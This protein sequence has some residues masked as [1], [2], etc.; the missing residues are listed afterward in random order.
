VH[1]SHE[2]T[3]IKGRVY[4][5]E[6]KLNRILKLLEETSQASSAPQPLAEKIIKILRGLPLD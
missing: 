2:L 4:Q 6:V 1:E 3:W 5:L